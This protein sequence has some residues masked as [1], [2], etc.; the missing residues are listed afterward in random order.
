MKHIQVIL[1]KNQEIA[2]TLRFTYSIKDSEILTIQNTRGTNYELRNALNGTAPQ[3]II[4]KRIGQDLL[5]ILDEN[6]GIGSP[7]EIT[8]DIII[9]DYYG[10]LEEEKAQ[11]LDQAEEQITDATGILIGLHE[12]GK[13]YAYVPES[14][15]AADAVSV[16]VDND[17]KPQ[18]IGGEELNCKV[19]FPWWGLLG[20]LPLAFLA[21]THEPTPE[22]ADKTP[23]AVDDVAETTGTTS[24]KGDLTTNDVLG[25]GDKTEHTFKKASDPLNG[26]VT[27]N[28]DGTYEYTPDKGFTGKDSFTYT[29]TDKDGYTSTATVVV[30][31]KPAPVVPTPTDKV[32]KAVDDVAETV[33]IKPVKGDITTNDALG[34][35]DKSEHTFAKA[36][37]PINGGTVVM[38]EDGTYTYT[39]K[40]GFV[41]KDSFTYTITD[42]DGD[43]DTATVVVDVKP[44][45][46][47][48]TKKPVA[49]PDDNTTKEGTPVT[50]DV[51][52]NDTLGDGD[53]SEHTFK[54]A[55]D[56]LNG[57]VTVNPDGTYEYTPNK[58]FTGK[59]TFEYT[60]VD[61][62]GDENTT[63]VVITVEPKAPVVEP[64]N[65]KPVA[66]PDDNTTKEFIS[67]CH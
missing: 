19:F 66:D 33:G 56:P 7:L 23:K 18:A 62:D 14:A 36:S 47:E 13:Y 3:N 24:V 53:K 20:L 43:T 52:K 37:D 59:D 34:D 49:D 28:P 15:E 42:K 38:N 31:V 4:T 61:K 26:T 16:L 54:K 40:A 41:G 29:I 44:V 2:E 51:T 12:N 32:P 48:P 9:K 27:V 67:I 58:G 22:S 17:A 21:H 46:V 6:E 39:P 11:G 64:V 55:S 60:I 5:I 8:P 50:G 45:L 25:D 57:T 10:D 63:K 35:G 65:K 1:H 30:D